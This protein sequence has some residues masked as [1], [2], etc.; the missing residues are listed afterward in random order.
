MRNRRQLKGSKIFVDDDLKK[1]RGDTQDD[2]EPSKGRGSEG[3]ESD[4]RIY[5]TDS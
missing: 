2:L 4:E 5:E 1:R 3:Q